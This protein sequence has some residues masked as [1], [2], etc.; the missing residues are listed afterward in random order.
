MEKLGDI[1]G[2]VQFR[3]IRGGVVGDTTPAAA[4]IAVQRRG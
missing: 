1:L 4:Q 2:A 3:Y